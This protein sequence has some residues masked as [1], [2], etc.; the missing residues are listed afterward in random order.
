MRYEVGGRREGLV[1]IL[2]AI[3][4]CKG[5]LRTAQKNS[6]RQ[7][8][9]IQ[10]AGRGCHLL[11]IWHLATG[12]SNLHH[13]VSVGQVDGPLWKAERRS[14]AVASRSIRQGNGQA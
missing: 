9:R 2:V 13:G 8:R 11:V 7:A 6:R 10:K 4:V 5:R 1:A 14:V 12:F 3:K